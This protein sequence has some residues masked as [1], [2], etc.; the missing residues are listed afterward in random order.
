MKP[1][2]K[3][4]YEQR[5]P[6]GPWS[7]HL[8]TT[9]HLQ[10]DYL[11]RRCFIQNVVIHGALVLAGVLPRHPRESQRRRIRA[12]K[13]PPRTRTN[14][15]P[16]EGQD[17]RPFGAPR[18]KDHLFFPLCIMI[19]PT[20]YF[21]PKFVLSPSQISPEIGR[22]PYTASTPNAAQAQ[23]A[24]AFRTYSIPRQRNTISRNV[25]SSA[26]QGSIPHSIAYVQYS[27]QRIQGWTVI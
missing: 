8:D 20:D 14:P 9:I 13:E 5:Q 24:S 19:L 16:L 21:N 10:P 17:A 4:Q 11:R 7:G 26:S 1:P 22:S 2:S 23:K 25:H 27:R 3:Q 15:A 6:E 12:H 18:L